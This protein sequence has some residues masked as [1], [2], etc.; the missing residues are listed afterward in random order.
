MKSELLLAGA[1]LSCA[2]AAIAAPTA[3]SMPDIC[4][5]AA[6][7]A[8]QSMDI[9][10]T[11]G[12]WGDL[13]DP[14]SVT[15]KKDLVNYPVTNVESL[16]NCDE[17][18][19]LNPAWCQIAGGSADVYQIEVAKANGANTY[20]FVSIVVTFNRGSCWVDTATRK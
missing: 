3:V 14:A 1:V 19:S 8:A 6:N 16:G 9:P 13:Q 5:S 15:L 10:F 17:D 7:Y 20:D 18:P 2:S 4:K 11:D 12:N